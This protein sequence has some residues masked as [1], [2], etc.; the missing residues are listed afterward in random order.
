MKTCSQKDTH[1]KSIFIHNSLKLEKNLNVHQKNEEMWYSYSV[2]KEKL[3]ISTKME[4]SQTH[5]KQMKPNKKKSICCMIPFI[6][7]SRRGKT[8]KQISGCLEPR[9]RKDYKGT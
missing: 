8:N 9:G 5:A 4:E 3:M 2:F 6:H 7:N 1:A